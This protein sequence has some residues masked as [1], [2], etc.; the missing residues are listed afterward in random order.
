MYRKTRFFYIQCARGLAVFIVMLFH[1]AAKG[2]HYFQYNYLGISKM[3]AS[4]AF[5]FFFV[6][7]G[8]LM[9]SLNQSNFGKK[10]LFQTFL[11]KRLFRIYSIYWLVMAVLIPIYFLV[12]SFGLGFERNPLDIINSLL[13]FPHSH[14]PILGVAWSLSYIVWFY[15]M[16]SLCF[17]LKKKIVFSIYFL[18]IIIIILNTL[19]LIP[20]KQ[21]LLAQFLFNEDHLD[22]FVGMLIGYVVRRHSLGHSFWWMLSGCAVYIT[23]WALRQPMIGHMKLLFTLGSGLVLL[24]VVTWKGKEHLWLRTVKYFG[25]ASYSILL[26]SLPMMSIT[27][28]LGRLTQAEN[29]LGAPMTIT[30]CFLI[31]LGLCLCFYRW[32]ERPLSVW[33]SKYLTK[34]KIRG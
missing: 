33:I 16:F 5:T 31:A 19:N 20:I 27:F 6:L 21:S 14:P 30:F 3:G 9:Y 4:G 25:D 11:L 29:R 10:A 1:A 34:E 7:T 24:G 15:I 13:L 12:P 8:Y 18:W 22:F 28:K 23:M 26:A 32:T 2:D 17:I